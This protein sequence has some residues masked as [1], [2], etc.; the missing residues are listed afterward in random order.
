MYR[1]SFRLI[2]VAFLAFQLMDAARAAT[3]YVEPVNG[4]DSNPGTID[5]P[6]RTIPRAVKHGFP[7]QY[8]QS[9]DVVY[10]RGGV[11]SGNTH[12]IDL[13]ASVGAVSGTETNPIT[14]KAYPGE[15]PIVRDT[16]SPY[17][18]V[19]LNGLNWWVFDGI[20]YDNCYQF[21]WLNHC[22]HI[23]FQ[24]CT[25]QNMPAGG[26]ANSG[27]AGFQIIGLSQYNIVRNCLFTR[28]G[29]VT[30]DYN[31]HGSSI[32]IGNETTDEPMYYN[33]I[34]NNRF[35]YGG[36]DNFGL[37]T[38][39]NVIRGNL[40]VNAPW[41]TAPAAGSVLT[42]LGGVP[43]EPNPYVLYGNRHTKPGDAGN[44]QIDMRNVW[45]RNTF[46]YAGPPPDDYGAFGIELGT[47]QSIYRFNTIAYSLAAGIYFNTS[48]T[49]SRSTGNTVY[50][51]VLYGNG[52]SH[53]YG[54]QGMKNYSYGLTMSTLEG[55]RTGN[56]VVNNIIWHNLPANVDPDIFKYQEFRGNFTDDLSNPLFMSIKGWGWHYDPDNVPDFRLR[57]G[58]PCID[59]GTWLART[60]SDGSGTTLT[61]DNALYFSDG[62]QIVEGDTI[63]LQGQT[64]TST[65]TYNDFANNTL[66][67]SSPLTWSKNQG[68]SLPYSGSAPDQ[69][70][71]EWQ[72]G[73]IPSQPATATG[74]L[75][76]RAP[77]SPTRNIP[78][79]SGNP[80]RGIKR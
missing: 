37:S 66:Y 51:N 17:R 42:S 49:D 59:A 30:D 7:I 25:F 43:A 26:D 52:L 50:S 65:V 10:L 58:S 80:R 23:L 45:E 22:K 57:N 72:A 78:P 75:G 40:F 63:Q 73:S 38:G 48:G 29:K 12:A 35:I 76:T 64:A 62:N 74:Q 18:G 61:V 20:T 19:L 32:V 21:V 16:T 11:Y 53:Q 69:G 9:G 13:N 27:Y 60:T 24:N 67:L 54:G 33:L 3:Y 34:E 8:R 36:H 31:D 55:R 56:F 70:A 5:Q 28:W 1:T 6:W 71:F 4:N 15:T 2:I 46:L 79:P 39:Y 41:M 14:I 68:V 77:E 44:F 47:M